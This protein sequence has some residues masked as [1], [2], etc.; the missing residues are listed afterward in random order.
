M[1]DPSYILLFGAGASKP[2]LPTAAEM[3]DKLVSEITKDPDDELKRALSFILG[4]IHFLRGC[5][6]EF[7]HQDINIEHVAMTLDA[8]CSRQRHELSPFVGSWNELLQ[9]F[10]GSNG[11]R[12]HCFEDLRCYLR[13][14]VVRWLKTPPIGDID[15]LGRLK[16]LRS[17]FGAPV[18]V[19]TLNYDLCVERALED[20]E[21]RFT[22]G[23]TPLGW[24]ADEFAKPEHDVRLYKL[25]G[26]LAWYRD[27]D[28]GVIYS[29]LRPP[30]DR[31]SMSDVPPLII[32]GIVHKMQPVDPFLYLSYTFSEKVKVCK[33]I[34]VVGYGFGDDYINRILGQGLAHD[35]RKRLVVV[36]RDADWA[37]Q[38][39]R[40]RFSDAPAL[41]DAGR[42]SFLDGGVVDA[43]K[44]KSL[45]NQIAQL[46]D[47]AS[48]SGPF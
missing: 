14:A 2:M 31:V 12:R 24:S 15:H 45:C 20:R 22:T 27:E 17:R 4:G 32:F 3:T 44:T 39:M 48:D 40:E 36:D 10:E 26:S 11:K 33:V 41:I 8:L 37:M 46:I 38:I 42:V 18:E 19:F 9:R 28:N 13:D 23:F 43:L 29:R 7:P 1:S 47:E 34:G 16:D 6:G 5:E 21:M 25:H 30:E 35:S